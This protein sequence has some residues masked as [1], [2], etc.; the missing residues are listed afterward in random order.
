MAKITLDAIAFLISTDESIINT[1][2]SVYLDIYHDGD[3]DRYAEEKVKDLT[4]KYDAKNTVVTKI[5]EYW[6]CYE[7][8]GIL[9]TVELPQ[10]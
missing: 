1:N 5:S 9:L 7:F 8:A 4:V 2:E 6:D 3:K 10:K